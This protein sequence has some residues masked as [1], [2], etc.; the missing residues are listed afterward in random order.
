MQLKR[1][2]ATAATLA[3]I[4][5]A[6]IAPRAQQAVW[7]ARPII[8]VVPFS[9][10]GAADVLMRSLAP[11]LGARLGGTIVVENRSGANGSIGTAFVANANPDGYTLLATSNATLGAN[12]AVYSKLSYDAARDFTAVAPIGIMPAALV[13]NKDLGAANFAEFLALLRAQKRNFSFGS[14][15]VGNPSHLAGER[16]KRRLGV[17]MEHVPY[18]G[19]AEIMRDL[20]S[21]QIQMAF[22][23]LIE[24]LPH[25]R[26]GSIL[27]VAGMRDVRAA[28]LPDVPTIAELGLPDIS[29]ASWQGIHGPRNMPPELVKR[30]NAEIAAIV[31]EPVMRGFLN[32][33]VIEPLLMSPEEFAAFDAADRERA[34]KVAAEAG[35]RLD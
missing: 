14:P 32:S 21:G 10:G 8:L 17:E 23:P 28:H 20:I 29:Y 33:I 3:L 27:A 22:S 35:V 25:V 19:G 30:L 4:F 31:S 26:A 13:V 7:P 16:F 12:P 11:R 34:V 24:S 2:T 18:R 5:C 15:G 6:A 1:L 9:A